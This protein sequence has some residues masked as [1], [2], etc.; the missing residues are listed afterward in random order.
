MT[1]LQDNFTAIAQGLSGAPKIKT[2]A[3]N[4]VSGSEAVVTAAIRAAAVTLV[5]LPLYVA[6]DYIEAADSGTYASPAAA[7]V[8]YHVK[9][10]TMPRGGVVRIVAYAWGILGSGHGDILL[11]KNG[12][13][14]GYNAGGNVP[15]ETTHSHFPLD[16]TIAAGDTI[17]FYVTMD[18]TLEDI[19]WG[20]LIKADIGS[21]LVPRAKQDFFYAGEPG[22]ALL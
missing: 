14:T 13:Y 19:G 22:E 20:A 1:S 4:Q 5:K 6:G 8:P 12:V 3:L 18:G 9:T 11:Y 21:V 2:A 15:W 16:L 17:G 7:D 10:F